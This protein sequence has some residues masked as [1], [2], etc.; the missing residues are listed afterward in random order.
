M[1]N[2]RF[3][4][5]K[6]FNAISQSNLGILYI[7]YRTNIP[8]NDYKT[9]IPDPEKSRIRNE[10]LL[11]LRPVYMTKTKCSNRICGSS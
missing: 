9:T 8:Y 7:M 2:V 3:E 1:L 5:E 4:F 11:L 10:S 6:V